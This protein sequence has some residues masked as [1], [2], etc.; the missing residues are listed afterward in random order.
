ME[1]DGQERLVVAHEVQREFLKCDPIPV[2]GAIREGV[3]REYDVQP[4]TIA[5]LKPGQIPKTSS[6]KVR[7]S[8]CRSLLIAGDLETIGAHPSSDHGFWK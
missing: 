5:L 1:Y 7:R 4:Y 3:A 6:G 8:L 2:I